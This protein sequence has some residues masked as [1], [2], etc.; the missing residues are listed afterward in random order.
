MTQ[1]SDQIKI[2]L[3][4]IEGTTTPV[5]Y[6]FG[7]LFPYA[8]DYVASF[9][10]EHFHEQGVQEDLRKL[11]QEY[12][13]D[14]AQGKLVLE[15]KNPVGGNSPSI[16]GAIAPSRNWEASAAVPYIHYLI[17][18]DRKST[19]LKSLQGKIWEEGYRTGKLRSQIFSDVPPA[20]DRWKKAGKQ[21]YIF[22]S[23]S[24]QAQKNLFRYTESGDLTGYLS[25]Y[26]DTEVG[27]KREP[28]SYQKITR[29]VGVPPSSI[30]FI[31]DVEAE[32]QTA[33]SSGLQ[34]LFSSRPGNISA[35]SD[36]FPVIQ[37]FNQVF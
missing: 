6:V 32:L 26:F 22:S 18:I 7:V 28:E 34:T 23:G 35:D 24:V 30:L 27:A 4:D 15:W 36:H 1:L 21:I 5:D 29:V 19:P 16:E 14:I 11:R 2:I 12:K 13:A 25:G 17:S 31:S 10:R 3:L 37:N 8:K 9:L 33:Q 20:F